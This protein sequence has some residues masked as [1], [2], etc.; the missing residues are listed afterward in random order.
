MPG[1]IGTSIVANSRKIHSG[2]ESA[3]LSANEILATRQ[4]LRG[5]GIDTAVM[6]DDDIQKIARDRARS[7]L[8]NAPMTAAA[9]AKIILDGVKAGNWR[10]LVG[11]D[12]HRLD[13][14][15]RQTPELAYEPEFYES[16]AKEVGWRLG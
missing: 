12:A 15:V 16:L 1:H 7:F 11:D 5:M 4:R 9:A 2:S 6:S 8:E 10:I 3:P 14:R 13:Q